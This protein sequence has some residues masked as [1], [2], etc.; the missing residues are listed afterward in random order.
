M[1]MGVGEKRNEQ[2]R[3]ARGLRFD[4]TRFMTSPSNLSCDIE[5]GGV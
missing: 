4:K 5:V 1:N 3:L 2:Q